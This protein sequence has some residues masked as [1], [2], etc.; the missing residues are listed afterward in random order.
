MPS[1]GLHSV[2][3]QQGRPS[4]SLFLALAHSCPTSGSLTLAPPLAGLFYF[5]SS[6]RPVPLEQ[7]FIGIK[8][9]ARSEQAKRN[10]DEVVF[11]K[12]RSLAPRPTQPCSLTVPLTALQVSELVAD[13]HQVMVFVHARKETVKSGMILHEMAQKEGN[14]DD[15]NCSDQPGWDKFR[16]EVGRSKNKEMKELFNY[17]IGIHHAG[18]LRSDRTLTEQMFERGCLK[19]GSRLASIPSLVGSL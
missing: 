13:N 6:F 16:L 1:S 4:L 5:D 15:F 17:G 10:M 18:M 8:G 2:S 7:H 12:V 11:D 3:R 9:K 14:T 19:V